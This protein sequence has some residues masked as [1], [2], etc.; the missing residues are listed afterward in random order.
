MKVK[1]EFQSSSEERFH[2]K[3]SLLHAEQLCPFIACGCYRTSGQICLIAAVEIASHMQL[4]NLICPVKDRANSKIMH[5]I[6]SQ[7]T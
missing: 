4:R 6:P 1:P 3:V 7:A 5:Y 2:R